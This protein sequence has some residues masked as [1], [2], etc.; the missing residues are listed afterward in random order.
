[1]SSLIFK[2]RTEDKTSSRKPPLELAASTTKKQHVQSKIWWQ[3]L[4]HLLFSESS[5]YQESSQMFVIDHSLQSP[6]S[7]AMQFPV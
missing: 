1:M 6:N 4:Q 2:V 3:C 5:I 7:I